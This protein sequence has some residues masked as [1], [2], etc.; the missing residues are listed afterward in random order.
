MHFQFPPHAEMKL[1]NCL[2]GEVWDVA[3]DIRTDSPTFLC[4]HGVYLSAENC[5]ALLI[6]PGFAHGFQTITD[7]VDMLYCHSVAH[8]VGYEGGLNPCDPQLASPWP[9]PI[10]EMSDR[11][12]SH[13]LI[14]SDFKGVGP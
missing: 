6:P 3:V 1:V 9:M 13:P 7:E 8:A 11:D 5:K 4:W 12:K 10:T 2:R 14:T